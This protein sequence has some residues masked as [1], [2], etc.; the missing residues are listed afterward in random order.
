M[1]PVMLCGHGGINSGIVIEYLGP[2]RRQNLFR[3]DEHE[4]A[5]F[6]RNQRS[7]STSVP[8]FGAHE[9]AVT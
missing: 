6:I 1:L 4:V 3:D 2:A 7:L 9:S 8:P 5:P